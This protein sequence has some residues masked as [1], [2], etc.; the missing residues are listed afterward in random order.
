MS[1]KRGNVALAVNNHAIG[2]W[3]IQ[4][5]VLPT[6]QSFLTNGMIP[7]STLEWMCSVV[8]CYCLGISV[9][10]SEYCLWPFSN[11]QPL[12]R[13]ACGWLDWR[14][15]MMLIELNLLLELFVTT[16]PSNS[17]Q[18]L[19]TLFSSGFSGDFFWK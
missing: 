3:T 2:H 5:N 1:C 11:I 8:V 15:G 19:V 16:V 9:N 18:N 10:S 12:L 14:L 7:R 13:L 4:I 17:P 6:V